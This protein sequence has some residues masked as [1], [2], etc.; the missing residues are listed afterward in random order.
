MNNNSPILHNQYHTLISNFPPLI[1][2]K[3]KIKIKTLYYSTSAP[4]NSWRQRKRVPSLL[5]HHNHKRKT[6]SKALKIKM[7]LKPKPQNATDKALG[8]INIQ[9]SCYTKKET[10]ELHHKLKFLQNSSIPL[11]A[12]TTPKAA[13][14]KAKRSRNQR[15]RRTI[16]PALRRKLR[17]SPKFSHSRRT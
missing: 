2:K 15:K 14:L 8:Q 10:L 16:S 5:P 17:N 1:Q 12:R 3:I 6:S 4:K 11:R 9:L 13:L 7:R